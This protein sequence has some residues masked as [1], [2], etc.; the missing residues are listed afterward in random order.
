MNINSINQSFGAKILDAEGAK[1][2]SKM[3]DKA[4]VYDY[5]LTNFC[6]YE[7]LCEQINEILPNDSDTVTFESVKNM[8]N[9][10]DICYKVEGNVTHNGKNKAFEL[11]TYITN[12]SFI[13]GRHIINSI[14]EAIGIKNTDIF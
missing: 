5:S 13:V 8:D 2:V 4:A 11:F 6:N 14:K 9:P 12:G 1:R 10:T 3:L 7:K